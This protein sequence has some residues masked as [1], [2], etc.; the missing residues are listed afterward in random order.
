MKDKIQKC[1]LHQLLN[2]HLP[3][4]GILHVHSASILEAGIIVRTA[5]ALKGDQLYLD[6]DH[7]SLSLFKSDKHNIN[8][9]SYFELH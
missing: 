6:P 2:N 8:I 3:L 1:A 4:T 7:F 5:L 9:L